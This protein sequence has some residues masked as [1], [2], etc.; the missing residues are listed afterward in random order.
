MQK[1]RFLKHAELPDNKEKTRWL[2]LMRAKECGSTTALDITRLC[3]CRFCDDPIIGFNIFHKPHK[4]GFNGCEQ[5]EKNMA[6]FEIKRL[7]GNGVGI[8][9]LTERAQK[10]RHLA[11]GTTLTFKAPSEA[12]EYVEVAE[13]E[14]FTF[15]GKELLGVETAAPTRH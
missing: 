1:S 14:G 4:V 9:P 7:N 3:A 5:R 13:Q 10:E 2:T 11:A 15:A 12:L 8:S 6:D